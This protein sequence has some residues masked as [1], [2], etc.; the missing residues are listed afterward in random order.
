[1]YAGWGAPPNPKRAYAIDAEVLVPL[2]PRQP[3]QI[4]GGKFGT[5]I[6][7]GDLFIAVDPDRTTLSGHATFRQG[8]WMVLNGAG[9]MEHIHKFQGIVASCPLNWFFAGQR[10]NTLPPGQRGTTWIRRGSVSSN[11]SSSE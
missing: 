9:T 3:H 2:V 8:K 1:M 6:P 7:E 10:R 11:P 5:S 4:A